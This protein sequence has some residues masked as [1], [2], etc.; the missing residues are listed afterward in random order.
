MGDLIQF[1]APRS[2]HWQTPFMMMIK[3][4][5]GTVNVSYEPD[6]YRNHPSHTRPAKDWDKLPCGCS[7]AMDG[8][9]HLNVDAGTMDEPGE[10]ISTYKDEDTRTFLDCFLIAFKEY[11]VAHSHHDPRVHVSWHQDIE[12]A[13]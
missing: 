12:E 7:L 9:G 11:W 8:M 4:A 10:I 3:R 1:P 5:K 2:G 6:D 13:G